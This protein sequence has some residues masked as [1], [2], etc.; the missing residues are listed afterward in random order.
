V[1]YRGLNEVTEMDNYPMP[2]FEEVLDALEG[3]T[4]FSKP[5]CH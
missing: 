1:D 4:V 3:A 5:D 2:M